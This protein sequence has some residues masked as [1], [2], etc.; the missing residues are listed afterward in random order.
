MELLINVYIV[1]QIVLLFVMSLHDWIHIPPFTDIRAL[2]R[3]SS[4][5]MRLI[6]SVIFAGVVL[7]PLYISRLLYDHAMT[8]H[9]AI[10][11][12]FA[13]GLLTIGTIASWW[14]PY[15][16]GSSES[17]KAHFIE[18]QHTHHFLPARGDNIVP[19][20]L[21]VILHVL[22]WSCFA[23]AIYFFFLSL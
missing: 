17:F 7:I 10:I 15:F 20:T 22:I 21:H 2:E 13:Y 8:P 9:L 18:Y 3:H 6:N 23:L 14:V 12:V 4:V 1:L 11:P 19:N 5:A 16:F